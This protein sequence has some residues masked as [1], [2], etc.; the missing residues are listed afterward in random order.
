MV[1]CGPQRVKDVACFRGQVCSSAAVPWVRAEPGLS[2]G[3][4]CS[5]P[6]STEGERGREGSVFRGACATPTVLIPSQQRTLPAPLPGRPDVFCYFCDI[7]VFIVTN[8]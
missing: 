6:E 4:T 1:H 7:I 3:E 5:S 8:I 2:P